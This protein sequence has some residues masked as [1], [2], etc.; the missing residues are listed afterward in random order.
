VKIGSGNSQIVHLQ[1]GREWTHFNEWMADHHP[2]DRWSATINGHI[3]EDDSFAPQKDQTIRVN[4]TG[5]GGGKKKNKINVWIKIGNTPKKLIPLIWNVQD[6]WDDFRSKVVGDLGHDAWSARISGPD[7]KKKGE[8]WVDNTIRP[9]KN[10]TV[11]VKAMDEEVSRVDLDPP[12]PI[13][14][15]MA[16]H[17][18]YITLDPGP[19]ELVSLDE[20]LAVAPPPPNWVLTEAERRINYEVLSTIYAICQYP[21]P[22]FAGLFLRNAIAA[23]KFDCHRARPRGVA[24]E[25]LDSSSPLSTLLVQLPLYKWPIP[26][27]GQTK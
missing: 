11:V 21:D 26:R 4:V 20:A 22:K 16:A 6:C 13:P 2:I 15:R 23:A 24:W 7:R 3:W 12:A 5:E 18:K 10:E 14:E 9:N 25:V 1:V 17:P 19:R 27:W 8:D